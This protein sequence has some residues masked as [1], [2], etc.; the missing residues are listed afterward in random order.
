MV[1]Y[2]RDG[3]GGKS[4]AV[5]VEASSKRILRTLKRGVGSKKIVFLY[6]R[7]HQLVENKGQHFP[8]TRKTNPK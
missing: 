8:K 2:Q 5:A 7:S 6:E 3:H 1:A 4:A